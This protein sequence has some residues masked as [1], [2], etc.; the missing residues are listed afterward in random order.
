[1]RNREIAGPGVTAGLAAGV[2]GVSSPF[3]AVLCDL[4]VFMR[5]SETLR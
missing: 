1:M 5:Q 2:P 4:T 3:C